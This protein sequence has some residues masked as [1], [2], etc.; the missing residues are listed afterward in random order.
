MAHHKKCRKIHCEIEEL[1]ESSEDESNVQNN[2]GAIQTHQYFESNQEESERTDLSCIS[3]TSDEMSTD[4]ESLQVLGVSSF[5]EEYLKDE[6][7]VWAPQNNITH[8]ALTSLL[9]LLREAGRT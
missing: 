6:L 9:G 5:N 7:A 4:E 8:Q 1:L 2:S 3:V